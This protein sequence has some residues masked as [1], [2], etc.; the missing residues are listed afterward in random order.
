[1]A[2]QKAKST[3]PKEHKGRRELSKLDGTQGTGCEEEKRA[4]SKRT[5]KRRKSVLDGGKQD[6]T[7]WVGAV[8]KGGKGKRTIFY[9]AK[10]V[11]IA[12]TENLPT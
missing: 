11:P 2:E 4:R 6:G 12:L 8:R 7:D 9:L 10:E 5:D 1:M 3:C